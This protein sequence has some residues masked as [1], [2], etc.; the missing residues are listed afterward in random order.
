MAEN[1]Q[2]DINL[3]EDVAQEVQDETSSNET[4]VTLE[5][6][7]HNELA[8]KNNQLLRLAAEYDNFRKRSQ[9]EREDAYSSAKA[10]VITE[11]LPVLDNIDRANEITDVTSE[12]YKKGIDMTFNQ[13]ADVFTKLSVESF[14]EP[15]DQFD[16]NIHNAVMHVEDENFGEN[17]V[18]DVFVKGYKMGERILRPAMVKVAN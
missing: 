8:D 2:Q 12:D 9:K 7:L 15:K 4:E 14:G 11:L 6:K 5:E 17:E 10:S 1:N 3:E 18:T 13:I 16:P